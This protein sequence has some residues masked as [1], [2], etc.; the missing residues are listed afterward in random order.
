[1]KELAPHIFGPE[2][3]EEFEVWARRYPKGFVLNFLS[4]N[5]VMIH[6]GECGHFA[7]NVGKDL[8]TNRKILPTEPWLLE[9]W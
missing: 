6:Y 1:L 7:G 8:V 5:N 2:T 9:A 4:E 3:R